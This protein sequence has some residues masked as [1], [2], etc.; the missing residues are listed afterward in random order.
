MKGPNGC[1]WQVGLAKRGSTVYL[2]YGWKEFVEAHHLEEHYVLFFR[3]WGCDSSGC[4][5]KCSYF[6]R[7]ERESRRTRGMLSKNSSNFPK[8][9]SP[10][11]NTQTGEDNFLGGNFR[12]VS[13]LI[14]VSFLIRIGM[15]SYNNWV[16]DLYI[17][18][19]LPAAFLCMFIC[20]RQTELKLDFYTL[21]LSIPKLL[22]WMPWNLDKLC[23]PAFAF[24]TCAH[25]YVS[26][27]KLL[28]S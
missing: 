11:N 21:N 22:I 16:Y 18:W 2:Q 19:S 1:S 7:S 23:M 14:L 10:T 26:L 4:E 8:E 12:K 13:L 20:T 17:Y 15:K 9:S 25:T 24:C 27:I 28:W 3:I 6:A 5:R